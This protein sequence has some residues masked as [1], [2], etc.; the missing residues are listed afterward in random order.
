MGD[1]H[2]RCEGLVECIAPKRLQHDRFRG[3]PTLQAQRFDLGCRR[4]DDQRGPALQGLLQLGLQQVLRAAGVDDRNL[5]GV[6]GRRGR[7]FALGGEDE[8]EGFYMAADRLRES[9]TPRQD[10]HA[11]GRKRRELPSRLLRADLQAQRQMERRADLRPALDGDGA[12]H[13]VGEL[14][15]NGEPEPAAAEAARRRLVRLRERLEDPADR[16]GVHAYARVRHREV[17][18][19]GVRR[20]Q[21]EVGPH[22]DLA[23]ARELHRIAHQVHQYLAHAQRVADQVARLAA[24]RT[25]DEIDTLGFRGAREQAGALLQDSPQLDGQL[26]Q[27]D[28]AGGNLRQV[29]QVVDDL[30]QHLGR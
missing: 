30:Q 19:H 9:G 25:H 3:D 21:I 6:A 28:L 12:P 10:P 20:G 17:H 27:L 26:L 29:E 23:S 1:S 13:Q 8:S 15:A 24:R 16:V 5:I 2:R 11:P 18:G 22:D 4:N 14:A 7:A